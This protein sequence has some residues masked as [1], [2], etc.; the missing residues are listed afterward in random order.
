MSL[1]AGCV[2]NPTAVEVSNADYGSMPTKELY[3]SK[4]KNYQEY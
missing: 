4:I 1:L 3:E 2:S